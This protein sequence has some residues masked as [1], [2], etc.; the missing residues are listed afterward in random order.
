MYSAYAFRKDRPAPE[1]RGLRTSQYTY[2][3][4]PDRSCWMFFDNHADPY[5]MTNLADSDPHAVLRD[6]LA[7]D[8]DHWLTRVGDP[9]LP[10]KQQAAH[11]NIT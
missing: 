5:Q 3:A 10:W 9:F 6:N 1:W 7:A 8:L 2:A 11:F 4:R